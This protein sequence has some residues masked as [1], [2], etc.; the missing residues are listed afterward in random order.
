MAILL[1]ILLPFLV[2]FWG[3]YLILPGTFILKIINP[4]S[5]SLFKSILCAIGFWA[6]VIIVLNHFCS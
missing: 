3:M 4:E 6:I 5:D 1:L 2:V